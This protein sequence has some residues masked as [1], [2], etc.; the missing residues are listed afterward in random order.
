MINTFHIDK[1][2]CMGCVANAEKAIIALPGVEKVE[3]DLENKSARIEGDI[4]PQ[5]VIE[6]VTAVGYPTSLKE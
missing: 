1:M 5:Q 3:I 2:K 4:D 6:A